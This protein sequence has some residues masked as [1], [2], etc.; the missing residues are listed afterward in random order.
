KQSLYELVLIELK[1]HQVEKAFVQLKQYPKLTLN[2][3]ALLALAIE[4]S[5][6]LGKTEDERDY[7]A[8]IIV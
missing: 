2:D 3:P 6:S 5:H 7:K 8:G 1:Q 4:V